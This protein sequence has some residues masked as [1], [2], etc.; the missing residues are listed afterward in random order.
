MNELQINTEKSAVN[1]QAAAQSLAAMDFKAIVENANQE[2]LEA[3]A[4]LYMAQQAQAA[5]TAGV[6]IAGINYDT[7][8]QTFL[9]N[10]GR[11]KSI[12]T[13]RTYKNALHELE[14]YCTA[15]KINPLEL[16]PAGADGFIYWKNQKGDSSATVR[17]ASAAASSFYTFLERRH[18]GIIFNPF[19][20]TKARPARTA[21][22]I[23]IPTET[24]V[25]AIIKA[26]PAKWAA[27]VS[28]LSYRGL[29]VGALAG[30]S[31]KGNRFTTRTKGK[32]VSGE[33]PLK[34]MKAIE[35]AALEL[36][37]PFGELTE[38]QLQHAVSYEL[39]KLYEAGTIRAAFSPHKF[40]HFYAMNEYRKDHDIRR[41]SKLLGHSGIAVTE[42]YLRGL[43]EID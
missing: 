24:D 1:F 41:V 42:N 39:K 29:R 23:D 18:S 10:A 40:R 37:K 38:A 20:G 22:K 13:M 12:H 19:R 17:T 16:T 25:K 3:M 6:K 9:D 15:S 27:A 33:L 21:A 30:I 2:Q 32:E 26:L 36:R 4:K 14:T 7:E 31:I 34:A 28:I 8:K 35:K 11:T 43:G 5:F